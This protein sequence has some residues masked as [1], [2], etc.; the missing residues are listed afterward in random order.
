MD[1]R[2]VDHVNDALETPGQAAEAPACTEVRLDRLQ[3][4]QHAPEQLFGHRR[5]PMLAGMGQPI[6]ARRG[7]AANPC[8]PADV[9]AQGIA[10]VVEPDRVRQLRVEHRHDVAPGTESA[11]F[12]VDAMLPG[13][14]SDHVTGD[15]IAELGENRELA[16]G[17]GCSSSVGFFHTRSLPRSDN[18]GQ[19]QPPLFFTWRSTS[20]VLRS[21]PASAPHLR[22]SRNSETRSPLPGDCRSASAWRSVYATVAPPSPANSNCF[23]H[24][25]TLGTVMNPCVLPSPGSSS[26]AAKSIA[27]RKSSLGYGTAVLENRIADFSLIFLSELTRH[28]TECYFMECGFGRLFL[29]SFSSFFHGR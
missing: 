17:W 19:L 27:G 7:R 18:L 25:H 29:P 2:G 28:K 9:V 24:Q 20:S 14:F 6:A 15:K 4:R 26:A 12:R 1:G 21:I 11:R 10:H 22:C 8:Q 16:S 3:V 23:A 5:I 13:Q